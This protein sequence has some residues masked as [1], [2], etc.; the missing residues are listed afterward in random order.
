M[1]TQVG[2]AEKNESGDIGVEEIQVLIFSVMGIR[3]GVDTE[4]VSSVVAP[5]QIDDEEISIDRFDEEFIFSGR[6]VVYQNPR[7]LCIQDGRRL[8]VDEIEEI[9]LL[10]LDKIRPLPEFLEKCRESNA[11]WGAGLI[12]DEIILL[13]NLLH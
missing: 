1:D 10:S 12:E 4:Q 5:D 8:M 6:Q 3:F 11:I 13:L 9:R 2:V 7:I